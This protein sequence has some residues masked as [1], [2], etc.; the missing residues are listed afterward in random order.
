MMAASIQSMANKPY[1]Q[2]DVLKTLGATGAHF[3]KKEEGRYGKYDARIIGKKGNFGNLDAKI[4]NNMN[5]YDAYHATKGKVN[6]NLGK[7]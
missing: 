7:Y 4:I 5:D 6:K 3:T 1:G 2:A